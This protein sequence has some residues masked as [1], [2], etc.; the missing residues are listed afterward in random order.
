M[1]EKNVI[2]IIIDALDKSGPGLESAGKKLKGL[3]EKLG[4]LGTKM[5]VAGGAVTGAMMLL[6]KQVADFGNQLD[7]DS[8]RLGLTVES[9]QALGFAAQQSGADQGKLIQALG[10]VSKQAR[11]ASLG[12]QDAIRLFKELGI[13]ATDSS[14]NLKSLDSILLQAADGLAQMED[15]TRAAALASQLFGGAGTDL[16]PMLK[17]GSK[18]IQEL[19]E[20]AARLGG[21]M[22]KE[23]TASAVAFT[24]AQGKMAFALQGVRNEI[25]TALAPALTDLANKLANDVIPKVKE[26][27]E[28]NQEA[29]QSVFKVGVGLIAAGGILTALDAVTSTIANLLILIPKLVGAFQ[30]L[31]SIKFVAALGPFGLVAAAAAL[32]TGAAAISLKAQDRAS[33]AAAGM[34]ADLRY[35]GPEGE[36]AAQARDRIL[37]GRQDA[38]ARAQAQ[39]G[40][41]PPNF[42]AQVVKPFDDALAKLEGSGR[43]QQEAAAAAADAAEKTR[44]ATIEQQELAE[45]IQ[46]TIR[47]LLAESYLILNPE[48]RARAFSS[49]ELADRTL[50]M[51]GGVMQYRESGRD[52]VESDFQDPKKLKALMGGAVPQPD[53]VGVGEFDTG[54]GAEILKRSQDA[55][56]QWAS[57]SLDAVGQV[58]NAFGSVLGNAI[59]QPTKVLPALGDAFK[60]VFAQIVSMVMAALAKLLLFKV[61]LSSLGFGGVAAKEL[62]FAKALGLAQGGIVPGFQGGGIIRG[63]IEGRDSVL[64]A[65]EPGEAILPKS[66]VDRVLALPSVTGGAPTVVNINPGIFMGGIGEA[67]E[68]ARFISR[69]ISL[70]D[71]GMDL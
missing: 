64:I 41:L 21:V 39:V 65:A 61:I 5:G 23:A 56:D 6:T 27:I 24:D 62:T 4:D 22:D 8:Q 40:D 2:Q 11:Q 14:G 44:L 20:E 32:V 52:R 34:A 19:T 43:S 60:Q 63:G 33:E 36:T 30:K 71:T 16:L 54:L 58:A 38:L 46:A 37:K 25:F 67:R 69:F 3:G 29:V 28:Q 17:R 1:T 57:F 51:P 70:N 47:G 42:A 15:S 13:K 12:S 50:T 7:K 59:L 35:A 48:A 53:L 66:L 45:K 49:Q 10:D 68:V 26:W 18:G 31:A 55:V 9:L